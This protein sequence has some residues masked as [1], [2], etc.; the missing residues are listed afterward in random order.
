MYNG[1]T[2]CLTERV[3]NLL[4]I[5][6]KYDIAGLKESCELSWANGFINE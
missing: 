6:E 1:K 5:T 2:H 4:E 3:T